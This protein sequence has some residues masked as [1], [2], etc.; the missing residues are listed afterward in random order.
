[1][2]Y[3][4]MTKGKSNPWAEPEKSVEQQNWENEFAEFRKTDYEG[5]PVDNG[6]VRT[7]DYQGSSYGIKGDRRDV[8][9]PYEAFL[10]SK[11][12]DPT[13]YKRARYD[14]DPAKTN[15]WEAA[16]TRGMPQPASGN[17]S[18]NTS[19]ST[20][21]S[22][23]GGTTMPS[24]QGAADQ[25][26]FGFN[27]VMQEFYNYKPGED[28]DEGRAI[29]RNFQA[30]MVQ[31]GF[32]H[33]LAESM[34][35]TQSG[36]AQSNMT[37]A[38]DLEQ[39][40]TAANMAQE[41][42]YGMQSMAGQ[43]ELQDKFADN[44]SERDLGMLTATGEQQRLLENSKG[45]QERYTIEAQGVQ[46]KQMANIQGSYGNQQANIAADAAKYQSDKSSE[47]SMY[48]A[49]R[50]KEASN[51]AADAN[52][53]NTTETGKQQRETMGYQNELEG[54]KENRQAAR[55]RSMARAF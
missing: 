24:R 38:A 39:R 18:P 13:E 5:K 55:S 32:D 25:G 2:K 49:D 53:R 36:I 37:H 28:D 52:I 8:D 15:P 12:L 14:E 23:Q 9:V 54:Q 10:K 6:L 16:N 46:N 21:T 4:G 43:F 47:A 30:N 26:N 22:P 42:N 29:K 41:F 48:G 51:Y 1:M 35:H 27:Q 11:G 40:N 31:S 3:G 7:A 20:Q 33:S 17:Q 45:L 44:Q 34:A 50:T 19:P